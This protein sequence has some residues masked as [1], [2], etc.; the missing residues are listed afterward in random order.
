MRNPWLKVPLDDY[1]AHMALPSVGQAS[2]LVRLLGHA[3][4]RYAPRSLAILGCSGGN[5]FEEASGGGIE[6][7]V[8]VDINPEYVALARAR[9]GHRIAGLELITG[10]VE[11][12]R[13]SFPPVEMVFAGLL[14][15]YVNV[16]TVLDRIRSILEPGGVLVTVVQL[17]S[18]ETAAVTPS[19]YTSLKAL[20]AIMRLVPPAA[21][22]GLAEERGY[23]RIEETTYEATGGKRLHMQT[24]RLDEGNAR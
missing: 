3:L 16:A 15:E 12:G 1:E 22:R 19:P 18:A 4:D 8:G 10:D 7:I 23:R 14:L 6:R 24:F 17:P 13:V 2:L 5:G 21:L 9:F 20:E 11:S